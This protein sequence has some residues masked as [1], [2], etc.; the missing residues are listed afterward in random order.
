MFQGD[1]QIGLES[2]RPKAAAV[3]SKRSAVFGKNVKSGLLSSQLLK[4][5][6]DCYHFAK[7]KYVWLF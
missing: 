7:A 2:V 1:E 3:C 6:T 5:E 4:I